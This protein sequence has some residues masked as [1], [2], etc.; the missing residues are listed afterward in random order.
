MMGFTKQN[1]HCYYKGDKVD[2]I[3]ISTVLAVKNM[4]YLDSDSGRNYKH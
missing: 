3:N 4:P 1:S 2:D